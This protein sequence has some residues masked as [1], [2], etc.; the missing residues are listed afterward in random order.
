MKKC[1]VIFLRNRQQC[2]SVCGKIEYG[3]H[4][5]NLEFC[6]F[7]NELPCPFGIYVNLSQ[8]IEYSF[9]EYPL[10]E[11]SCFHRRQNRWRTDSD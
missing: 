10:D 4:P 9:D 6:D 1:K 8:Y 3:F 11:K 7:S 2:K 5:I